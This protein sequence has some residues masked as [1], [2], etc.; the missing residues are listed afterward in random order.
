[1]KTDTIAELEKGFAEFPVMSA[2]PV[3]AAE[4]DELER[5]VGFPLAGDYREFIARYGG[6][7]VGPFRIFGL[8]AAKAMGRN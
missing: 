5:A 2:G 4:I 7:I 8:R 3:P 1:M 6:A